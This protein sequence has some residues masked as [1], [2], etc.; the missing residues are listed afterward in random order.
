MKVLKKFVVGFL[1]FSLIISNQVQIANAETITETLNSIVSEKK[2]SSVL[3]AK[4]NVLLNDLQEVTVTF[5]QVIQSDEKVRLHYR[6]LNTQEDFSQDSSLIEGSSAKFDLLIQEKGQFQVTKLEIIK[7][8]FLTTFEL[9]TLGIDAK[10]GVEEVVET[11]PDFVLVEQSTLDIKSTTMSSVL[12]GLMTS[13]ISDPLVIVIDP[14]HGGTDPGAVRTYNNIVYPERD[15]VLKIANA[16]EKELQSYSNVKVYMTRRDNSSTLMNRAERIAFA[17]NVGADV[18]VSLHLNASTNVSASGA[19]V[20]VPNANYRPEVGV[21]GTELGNQILSSLVSNG[22]VNR[23]TKFITCS[24]T[25]YPDGSLAD[26]Y[27]INYYAKLE[28]FPG[29]IVEHCFLSNPSD[30]EKY[31]N[32]DEKLEQLGIADATGIARYYGLSQLKIN[33]S[34]YTTYVGLVSQFA[35]SLK[36]TT[37]PNSSVTWESSDASIASVD[38]NGIIQSKSKGN[39]VIRCTNSDGA[40]ATCIVTVNDRLKINT[41]NYSCYQGQSSSFSIELNGNQVSNTEV[42]WSSNNVNIA[43][44]DN[45]G[46]ITG[47]APGKVTIT[48]YHSNTKTSD[49]VNVEV[50]LPK[51]VT[52]NTSSYSCFAG[53]KSGLAA[54]VNGS[55]VNNTLMQWSSLNESVATIDKNGVVYGISG[56]ETT[57]ECT[58]SYGTV[59]RCKVIVFDK[60]NINTSYYSCYPGQKS[61]FSA[62]MNGDIIDNSTLIWT[63]NNSN[64]AKV[65]QDGSIVGVSAGKAII[66]IQHKTKQLSSQCVVEVLPKRQ[67]LINTNEYTCYAGM[68]SGFAAY[69]DG[70]LVNNAQVKWSTS[71]EQIAHVDKDGIVYG[72]RGGKAVIY[73][74]TDFGTTASCAVTVV[75]SLK[76]NTAT[77]ACYP[78]QKSAFSVTLDGNVVENS[79]VIWTSENSSIA[80]IDSLGNIAGINPGKTLITVTDKLTNAISKCQVEIL[81]KK[82]VSINI[83]DY[84]FYV[85][86]KSGFAGYVDGVLASNLIL[87]WSS[88]NDAIASIDANG[89]IT[90]KTSGITTIYCTTKYGTVAQCKVTVRDRIA[91]N[92]T[93]YECFPT[94]KS[95]FA[96]LYNNI[97]TKNSDFIWKFSNE[98]IATIDRDGNIYGIS[99]G[100]TTI[101]VTSKDSNISSNCTVKV[102]NKKNVKI[103]TNVFECYIGAITGFAATSD[104]VSNPLDLFSW[105]SSDSQIV[106]INQNGVIEALRPGTSIISCTSKYGTVDECVVTVIGT[107]ISGASVATA[108]QMA[109][110]YMS[111]VQYY[112]AKNYPSFYL[113]SDAKTIKQ[114]CEIFIN[115]GQREGIRG[116]LAFCQAMLE[117]GFLQLFGSVPIQNY[118]FAGLGATGTADAPIAVFPSVRIGIRAQIQHL[119]AY[120]TPKTVPINE[121]GVDPRFSLVKRGVAPYIEWLG[122]QENPLGYGWATGVNYGYS[123]M[124]IYKELTKFY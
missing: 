81:P 80:T 27:G 93:Y 85:G 62:E 105:S 49:I 68:K 47:K 60:L 106:T 87:Q 55:L 91:I 113:G 65:Y 72:I 35:V 98:S 71:N 12:P 45:N 26:N 53:T 83:N 54:Y 118:N 123:I 111:K 86:M 74:T 7:D 120:A 100:L 52:V 69:V 43:T 30:F 66:T 89:L 31:L 46:F 13:S 115:E 44:I 37:I 15:L 24:D 107:Q 119:K 97:Q 114:F 14:G 99:P 58:T 57:I 117:T 11:S 95:T 1:V 40:T 101:T 5:D 9:N 124:R 116:D 22:V 8:N 122:Q 32:T 61:G 4:N 70:R 21:E 90:G 64:I 112:A 51:K 34:E 67:V 121:V 59:A 103:N 78:G 6:N 50:L 28:G 2:V 110:Y 75:S 56:G 20:Y 96:V 108:D 82:N 79:S 109:A 3:V 38:H 77:Y 104:G 76:I 29:I 18:I 63:S 33:V 48:A 19:E 73:C 88:G 23:G 25:Y 39:C 84:T 10:F 41:N 92:T 16:C 17:K 94:Q 36:N 42:Q 102:L